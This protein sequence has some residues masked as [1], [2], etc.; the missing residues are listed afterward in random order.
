MPAAEAL[1]IPSG[2]FTGKGSRSSQGPSVEP[3]MQEGPVKNISAARGIDERFS[4]T[5]R[6]MKITPLLFPNITSRRAIGY[7]EKLRR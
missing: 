5:G 6:L 4:F 1:G 7:H 3:A 2:F